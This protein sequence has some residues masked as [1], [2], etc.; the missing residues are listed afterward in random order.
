MA[1]YIAASAAVLMVPSIKGFK[2]K[3]EAALSTVDAAVK[4]AVDLKAGALAK[5]TAEIA[6]W[7]DGIERDHIKVKVDA[8]TKGL[9][10][11]ITEIRHQYDDLA[12]SFKKGLL[13]N[14]KITGLSLLPQ[15][16]TALASVNQSVVALS[17]STLLLPGILAGAASA[18]GTLL[19]G[20]HGVSGAFKAYS[21]AV[22]D[23]AG[24]AKRTADAT[25]QLT[26]AN[27][28]LNVATRD[29]KRSLEDLNAQMRDAPTDEATAIL[30]LKDAQIEAAQVFGKTGLQRQRDAIAV[31]KAESNLA[32]TRVR[33]TR[34]FQDA[35]AANKAGVAG[36]PAV[37][38]ALDR[39]TKAQED[40][41]T[42]SKGGAAIAAALNKLSPNAQDFVV[43]IQSMSDS[44][45]KFRNVVQDHLFAGLGDEVVQLGTKLPVVEK[46]FSRIADG[47]N[48][49]FKTTLKDLS[50][51][52]NVGFLDRIFGNTGDA[53]ARLGN[54]LKPLLD[55]FI[56][57]AA[58][59]SDFLPRLVNGFGTLGDKFSTFI[60]KADKDGSL[61]KWINTG[62]QALSDLGTSLGNIGSILNSVSEAFTGAGGK[63]FLSLLADGT[64]KLADF[65]KG[66]EGQSKLKQFFYDARAE[67]EKWMPIFRDIP[68]LITTV[69][70]AAQEWADI[71]LPFLSTTVQIL[72]DYP[73][74]VTAVFTAFVG[75]KTIKPI[76][77]GLSTALSAAKKGFELL[78]IGVWLAAEALAGANGFTGKVQALAGMIGTGGLLM[79]ALAVVGTALAVN[80]VQDQQQAAK[81]TEHHA[82]MVHRLTGEIDDLSGAITKSGLLDKLKALGGFTSGNLDGKFDVPALA[83]KG[84]LSRTQFANALDPANQG[85]RDF[86]LDKSYTTLKA[87]I[88]KGDYW[89]NNGAQLTKDGF[90]LDDLTKAA[91]GD[92]SSVA[93]FNALGSKQPGGGAGTTHPNPFTLSDIVQGYNSPIPGGTGLKGLDE[94]GKGASIVAGVI[95]EEANAGLALGNQTR[96]NNA[97]VNGTDTLT[98]AG[99]AMF[100]KFG[101]PK[102]YPT[103][104]GGT[105]IQVDRSL[106]ELKAQYPQFVKDVEGNGGSITE[107]GSGSQ[108]T[109][110]KERSGQYVTHVPAMATGGW[111][112]GEGSGTSDSN[113][114]MLSN[115][116]HVTPA[117]VAARNPA[118][119]DGM[120]SGAIDPRSL[121][122]FDVGGPTAPWIKP[123]PTPGHGLLPDA[124]AGQGP[125]AHSGEFA[126]AGAAQAARRGTPS[127]NFGTGTGTTLPNPLRPKSVTADEWGLGP[128]GPLTKAGRG[129]RSAASGVGNFLYGALGLSNITGNPATGVT[130][131]NTATITPNV[132]GEGPTGVVAGSGRGVGSGLGRVGD[133]GGG[134]TSGWKPL[135]GASRPGYNGPNRGLIRGRLNGVTNTVP[136][137][138]STDIFSPENT[139]P[140]LNNPGAPGVTRSPWK[141]VGSPGEGTPH[142]PSN[143]G[144]PGPTPNVPAGGDIFSPENTNPGLS[145]PFGVGPPLPAGSGIAPP[146][147]LSSVIPGVGGGP[148]GAAGLPGLS[149][150][151][152][153]LQSIG[154]VFLDA[155]LGFFGINPEYINTIKQSLG[156]LTGKGAADPNAQVI[157]D[158]FGNPVP[159]GGPGSNQIPFVGDPTNAAS[160]ATAM[161][162][163]MKGKMYEWGGSTLNGTDCS[164][165]VMYIADAYLGKQ[166]SGRSGGTGT[167]G[168]TLTSKGAIVVSDPSQM[169]PGTLRIG[170]NGD[171]TSGTLPDGRPFESSTPGAPIK[172][173]P[174]ATGYNN[175]TFTNWA[176]F[177]AQSGASSVAP[178]AGANWDAMS[179]KESSGNWNANTGNGYYGGLQ[180]TQDS[181]AAAGGLNFAARADLA[182][183]SQQ[184]QIAETLLSM[185]GPGAWPNTFIPA[186]ANGWHVKGP[187]SGT[188]DSILAR[189]SD[190]EFIT[191]ASVVSK[192]PALFHGLNSGAIDPRSLAGFA[193]GGMADAKLK[194]MNPDGTVS[195]RDGNMPVKGGAPSGWN[196]ASAVGAAA[197]GASL[198]DVNAADRAGLGGP[199]NEKHTLS[200]VDQGIDG[201]ATA[202]GNAASMAASVATMGMGG[203]GGGGV[204]SLIGGATQI[205]SGVAKGI[206]NIG[207]SLLVGTATPGT[208]GSAYG[209]PTLPQKN[210]QAPQGP[211]IVNQYGDIH[212][213]SYDEFYKGQQRREQQQQAPYVGSLGKG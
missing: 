211:Q 80:Y 207:A 118:L 126:S 63:G 202:I 54:A 51:D 142:L 21:T 73:T 176:Y 148:P 188:S 185:Q 12:G 151:A 16:G 137:A 204:G 198:P 36:N 26:N 191:R 77:D 2:Q 138:N 96:T 157:L 49:T 98:P 33:N 5:P 58:V 10:K 50:S 178:P 101:S 105:S 153:I 62:I 14:L 61:D 184:K 55:G 27:R 38:D 103:S 116:E 170:W 121:A 11:S 130:E 37:L 162:E 20:L 46:G 112:N 123:V 144:A 195:T 160:R 94:Q 69:K 70:N 111:V 83:E 3:L 206:A 199:P 91:G 6:A 66:A 19:T 182:S 208:T 179:V 152:G 32:N 193:L 173:G 71:F 175:P 22:K 41:N 132:P 60:D 106:A 68:G 117:A 171:H 7:K 25:R 212:T 45:N 172:L 196:P 129:L 79:G 88:Q 29:A 31:E 28:D 48:G 97:A 4:V 124:G 122:R 120:T 59:G 146:Q 128:Q 67:L 203:G 189:V 65:L 13:L 166:F 133:I 110:S 135:P 34:I 15:L 197:P 140:A 119:F 169:P 134:G 114:R 149:Q 86:A 109:L 115:K 180:F 95:N 72:K 183:P 158:A 150:P 190:G 113:L 47:L 155:I 30:D 163:Q 39:Q 136:L 100:G 125:G 1:E 90:T 177:P 131:T 209:S 165:L 186:A 159:E 84:G 187:G 57:L 78:K 40:L 143:A 205:G 108:I 141:P 104:G 64:G 107:L 9:N 200:A 201:A 156:F 168:A 174:G 213:A 167:E 82:D 102:A 154:G 8:D 53:S 44:F 99:Q 192:N 52:K 161:A 164:G 76:I 139:N 35:D 89:K 18:F 127:T 181:W 147:P 210:Q 87:S 23:S 42:A 75:W 24:D 92:A 85:A 145:N 43:K 56:H 74:L 93:K 17:Q 194:P 81:A